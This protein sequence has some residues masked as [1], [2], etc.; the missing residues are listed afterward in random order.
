MSGRECSCPYCDGSMPEELCA[1][2]E[3]RVVL[4]PACGEPQPRDASVCSECGGRLTET[5][6]DEETSCR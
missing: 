5:P 6:K 4:C 2:C 1:P 3:V